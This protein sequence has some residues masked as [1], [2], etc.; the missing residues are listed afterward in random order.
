VTFCW[1]FLNQLAATGRREP[2]V[3]P[4][5]MM[6]NYSSNNRKKMLST[7]EI[8]G[9]QKIQNHQLQKRSQEPLP[10]AQIQGWLSDDKKFGTSMPE[11]LLLYTTTRLQIN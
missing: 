3:S 2:A 10:K 7:E 4:E 11:T 1:V 5:K 6:I 9:R 8:L